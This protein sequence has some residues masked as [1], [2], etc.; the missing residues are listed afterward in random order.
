MR[1]KN[2]MF[3]TISTEYNNTY[4]DAASYSGVTKK[5]ILLLAI[6]IF[7]AILTI[8]MLFKIENIGAFSGMLIMA[9]IFGFISVIVGRRNVR[10]SKVCAVIYAMCEGLFLGTISLIGEMYQPGIAV[11]AVIS[12][13]TIFGIMLA[14]FATGII[15]N[16]PKIW[17]VVMAM[18]IGLISI[19]L[20]LMLS[21]IFMPS[22]ASFVTNNFAII[23]G[24]ELLFLIYGAIMLLANFSEV[25]YYVQGGCNKEYEWTAAFGL[26]V[27]ILYIYI[28][29]VRILILIVGRRD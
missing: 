2:P 5:T 26:M 8:S 13:L 23:L 6:S 7:S 18:G 28:E 15:R 21:Q 27:S 10:A 17:T 3:S 24:F 12:T 19:T 14:L 11:I 9:S 4:T 16:T 22:I 25:T 29:V 1:A 20:L